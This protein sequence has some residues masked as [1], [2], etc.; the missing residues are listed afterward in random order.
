MLICAKCQL[1]TDPAQMRG[2]LCWACAPPMKIEPAGVM[3]FLAEVSAKLP[4]VSKTDAAKMLDA[5][6]RCVESL[7]AF[8]KFVC[9]KK[10]P[11]DSP[12]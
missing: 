3:D 4:P 9:D 2:V 5:M 12:A 8:A 1:Q 7:Q 6:Q 11:K 10:P